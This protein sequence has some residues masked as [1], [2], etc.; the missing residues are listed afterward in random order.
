M[1]V[2][3]ITHCLEMGG[4]NRSM[5][6]LILE[7]RDN[8]GVD[9]FVLLPEY[10]GN[11]RTI[12]DYLI[13]NNINF[14]E[15]NIRCFKHSN[16]FAYS[17]RSVIISHGQIKRLSKELQP[18][19]F[20]FI[21][22]NSSVIDF[23]GFLSRELGVKHIWH[24]RE[25]GDLD[26]SSKSVFGNLYE[27]LTYRNAE[28]YI[29]ISDSIKNHFCTKVDSSKITTI[30]NGIKPNLSIPLSSHRNSKVQFLCAGIYAET[31]N[32]LEVFQAVNVLVNEHDIT[33]FH[34]TTVGMGV[35]SQYAHQ[36]KDFAKNHSIE[37]YVSILGEVDGIAAL[38]STMDVGIISS[39]N[40]AFGRVTVEFMLQNLAV[41]ANDS[42]AN[43]EIIEHGKSG[44]IYPH[45]DYRS[46]A[47]AMKQLIQNQSLL[48]YLASNG[49]Q[50]ANECFLSTYNTKAVFSLYQ[51]VIQ[52]RKFTSNTLSNAV[53][54]IIIF[55]YDI[56]TFLVIKICSLV[57][58]MFHREET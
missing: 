18:Y 32:Q 17:R 34:L 22:S 23:G 20:D 6:Q 57:F 44:L 25:F 28:L 47:Y 43:L 29:A 48:I 45:N 49:R 54:S 50:R 30:Y 35:D 26:Y 51:D 8:Y 9:P 56:Y 40:E 55:L 12:K 27:R 14:K 16:P 52:S 31:K 13:E 42:G 21:H 39:R 58:P 53:C 7:L 4:A 10:Q 24:F 46:L 38:A 33:E 19:H 36:L 3:Y 1:K 41:I 2:L 37:Q 11:N 5:L 15:S